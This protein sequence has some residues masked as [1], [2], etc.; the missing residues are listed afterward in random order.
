MTASLSLEEVQKI[1]ASLVLGAE[2]KNIFLLRYPQGALL[3][4]EN[5]GLHEPETDESRLAEGH[6]V[7][8][9]SFAKARASGW[10]M[11]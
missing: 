2:Y 10:T 9:K 4:S 8:R 6:V 5:T 7:K 11:P 3:D 1:F